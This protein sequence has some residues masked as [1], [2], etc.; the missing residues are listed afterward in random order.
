MTD[1]NNQEQDPFYISPRAG[2]NII[3]AAIVGGVALTA[4]VLYPV[5]SSLHSL[6][7][8]LP[9]SVSTN[10]PAVTNQAEASYIP[11]SYGQKP[12]NPARTPQS[13]STFPIEKA[14]AQYR[15]PTQGGSR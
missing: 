15:M 5:F 10:A 3:R 8:P 6:T 9:A 7:R 4:L 12:V 14:R 13:E 11:S 1:E 2:T